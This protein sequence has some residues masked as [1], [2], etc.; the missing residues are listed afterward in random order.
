V[1]LLDKAQVQTK[2]NCRDYIES[3][4]AFIPWFPGR[5]EA[6]VSSDTPAEQTRSTP[7]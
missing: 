4:S 2:P 3:T 7:T 1:A 5:Q 6:S